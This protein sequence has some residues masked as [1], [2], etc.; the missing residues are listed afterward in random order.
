MNRAHALLDAADI[1]QAQAISLADIAR[2]RRLVLKRASKASPELIGPCP[3][4]GRGIDR[5]AINTA[6]QVFNCRVCGNKGSGAIS[7]VMFLDNVEFREAVET[8]IGQ[9]SAPVSLST[10]DKLPARN[11]AADNA[12]EQRR[13]ARWLWSQRLPVT[14]TIAE[15]YLREARDITCPLPPTLAFLPPSKPGHHPALISAF[16]LCDESEPGIIAA[17]REVVAVH[18][19]LLLPDGSGKIE[20][21]KPDSNKLIIASPSCRPIV[22]AP[23]NDLMGL[24]ITEGIEDALS[25]H[26]ALG[27]G[28]WAA[29]SAP[30]M[31]KLDGVEPDF[32]DS[33]VPD[34][35]D[36]VTIYADADADQQGERNA[37]KLADRLRS[38]GIEVIIEGPDV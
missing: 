24:A 16:G 38:R 5:F 9:R 1:A 26:Q 23:P 31:G 18:L 4:C 25:A 2:E 20:V 34:W 36:C 27:L 13:K 8:L 22:V 30:H 17:P 12:A 32:S 35:I 19:T 6:K 3:R 14:G 7:L 10:V 11:S 21:E 29:G 33:V 15:K 37:A 28:A